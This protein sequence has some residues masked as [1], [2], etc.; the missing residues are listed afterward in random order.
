MENHLPNANL[1]D[2]SNLNY[3]VHLSS[4]TAFAAKNGISINVYDVDDGKRVVFPLCVTD[5]SIDGKRVDLLMHES[6]EIQHYSTIRNFSR[7]VSGQ[8]SKKCLHTCSSVAVLKRH[9]KRCTH[10]QLAKFPIDLGA[11]LPTYRNNYPLRL[12]CMQILNLC[13]NHLAI[14]RLRKVS[15]KGKKLQLVPIKSMWRVVSPIKL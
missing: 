1:Y 5:A 6:K 14:W 9:M 2:F 13:L 8:L 7:L 12:L 3:P 11:V 4:I 15:K 10:V